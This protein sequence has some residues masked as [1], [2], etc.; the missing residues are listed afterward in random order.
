[1]V[2]FKDSL[3][4]CEITATGCLAVFQVHRAGRLNS[5]SRDGSLQLERRSLP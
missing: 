2:W 3:K 5:I 1:L 4:R